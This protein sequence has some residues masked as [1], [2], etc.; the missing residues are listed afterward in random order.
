MPEA[1]IQPVHRS[2]IRFAVCGLVLLAAAVGCGEKGKATGDSV[3][4]GSATAA[5]SADAGGA[6]APAGGTVG[7]STWQAGCSLE[8]TPPAGMRACRG[9]IDA[10]FLTDP[11]VDSLKRILGNAGPEKTLKGSDGT[12]RRMDC[13]KCDWQ[14]TKTWVN[15]DNRLYA[16]T[17]LPANRTVL[18]GA[19]TAPSDSKWNDKY[20]GI[21]KGMK[22]NG[23]SDT[24]KIFIFATRTTT[25]TN[26][27]YGR[28][29]AD[30]H[31]VTVAGNIVNVV[32]GKRIVECEHPHPD[33]TDDTVSAFV[34]CV[35]IA[36][37]DSIAKMS[38][39]SFEQVLHHFDRET[40]S[41]PTFDIFVKSGGAKIA[42]L[43]APESALLKR[44][45]DDSDLAGAPYWFACANGCCTAEMIN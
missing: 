22:G 21:G 34:A 1:A 4:G 11:K 19:L 9:V 31:F 37:I 10:T 35:V 7:M 39:M 29:I 26:P 20:Y 16:L 8:A 42:S 38:G 12:H 28:V 15:R 5:T 41:P 45:Y 27:T 2:T 18:V 25:T 40:S 32:P 36:K 30:F 23:T 13:P 17:D 14:Y 44:L 6:V 33:M 24:R 3:V 43:S